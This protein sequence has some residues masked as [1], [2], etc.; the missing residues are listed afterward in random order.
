MV[1]KPHC[2]RCDTDKNVDDRY[3]G[4]I[5]ESTDPFHDPWVET[6]ETCIDLCD[7][8]YNWYLDNLRKSILPV[9][10]ILPKGRREGSRLEF[11][12]E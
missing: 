12:E 5:C 6:D 7:T 4:V 3:I 8:C 2:D 11:R 1:N 10:L 9:K